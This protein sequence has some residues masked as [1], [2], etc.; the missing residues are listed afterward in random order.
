[1]LTKGGFRAKIAVSVPENSKE[2][3][4]T[5]VPGS[6]ISFVS[7]KRLVLCALMAGLLAACTPADGTSE[8]N[9]PYEGRNRRVHEFNKGVDRVLLKPSS[10]AYGSAIPEPV[11]RGV[12]NAAANLNL[13]GMVANNLLQG[14]VEPL[15]KNTFRFLINSTVGIGG[16]FD[17]ASSMGLAE[18]TTDFGETLHVWGVQQGAYL[19][20]PLLGP[21]SERDLAGKVV[22]TLLNPLNFLLKS[23]EIDY[24]TGLQIAGKFNDRYKYSGFVDSIL[25]ESADSYAQAR[26]LYLQNRAFQLGAEIES[27]SYDPYEDPYE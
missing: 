12:G 10:S 8:F 23:P 25:Y 24:A 14:R 1:M 19:E 27:D 26:L 5:L 20:L 21:S 3:V 17:P 6:K 7:P 11:R 18:E 13:P 22:D 16:L 2:A 9:D 4:D 15:V